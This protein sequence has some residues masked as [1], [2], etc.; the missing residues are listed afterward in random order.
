M[1]LPVNLSPPSVDV[2]IAYAD[3]T[4]S[5]PEVTT[6]P[7]EQD[8]GKGKVGLEETFCVVDAAAYWGNGDIKLF[9]SQPVSMSFHSML[10][11]AFFE[12]WTTY[13]CNQD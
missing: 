11:V 4:L 10:T 5:L 7:E 3:P 2:D 13:L 1:F 8:H 9:T 6:G 12:R